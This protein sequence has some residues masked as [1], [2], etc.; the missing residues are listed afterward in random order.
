MILAHFTAND[1]TSVSLVLG[2]ALVVWGLRTL[3]RGDAAVRAWG[4]RFVA[5]GA[6]LLAVGVAAAFLHPDGPSR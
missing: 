3:V 6:V 2:M 4:V 1:T 5:V